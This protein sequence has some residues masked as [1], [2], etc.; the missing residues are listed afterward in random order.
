MQ[1]FDD[2]TLPPERKKELAETVPPPADDV[3]AATSASAANAPTSSGISNAPELAGYELLEELGR[4]GMGVVYKARKR[5]LDRTVAV[6][7]ILAGQ[8]ASVEEVRRFKLEAEAAARLDHPG[9]VPIYD[10]G[11]SDGNHFYSMKY[12]DGAALADKPERYLDDRRE[13]V[14]LL[15]QVAQAVHHA[16]QRGVLHRDLKPANILIDGD[17]KPLVTDL[18]LAKRLDSE[19]VTQTGIVMGT[20]GFMAP[21]QAAG[22]KDVTT[23]A[24]VFS[25]GAILHWLISGKAPFTGDSPLQIIMNTLAGD[26]PSL[27]KSRADVDVGLDLICQKC[28]RKDPLARY[29]SAAALV[30]DLQAWLTG[31]PLSVRPPTPTSLAAIWFKKNLRTVA[32]ACGCGVAC[33]LLFGAAFLMGQL[34]GFSEAEV[35]LSALEQSTGSQWPIH[36]AFLRKLPINVVYSFEFLIVIV[37]Y[38][39]AVITTLVVRPNSREGCVVSA[40]TLG[41]LAGVIAH[42]V[43]IG[44]GPIQWHSVVRG[45][46]DIQLL[47]DAIFHETDTE[48][49][50]TKK[51]LMQRYPGLDKL[52]RQQRGTILARKVMHDQSIGIPWGMW[53]GISVTL[54]L[55]TLPL[56]FSAASTGFLWLEGRRGLEFLG[57]SL[58][59]SIYIMLL[60]MFTALTL[61]GDG[62]ISAGI[63]HSL[64]LL[65]ALIF[66]LVI[67]LREATWYWRVLG[68]AL[69]LLCVANNM[70]E[71]QTIREHRKLAE[72]ARNDDEL[73]VA[74]S[75]AEKYL[76]QQDDPFRRYTTGILWLYL[77]D[78][79]RYQRHCDQLL[80]DFENAY[81][82]EVAER[83]AKLALLKPDVQ[84]DPRTIHELAEFAAGYESDALSMWF[85]FCRALSAQRQGQSQA[86]LEWTALCRERIGPTANRAVLHASSFVVDALAFVEAGDTSAAR[87]ALDKAQGIMQELDKHPE[88]VR[89]FEN[90][91]MFHILSREA[92]A[93]LREVG[94]RH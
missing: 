90:R 2:E 94:T 71:A 57:I 72:E 59:R 43:S 40:A 11:E 68:F 52:S 82:P 22:R 55:V 74:A 8:F 62:P 66:A 77:G 10:V 21:E 65:G 25:L 16:H 18:G 35:T 30:E 12:I 49:T 19:G 27:R 20:P 53:I 34:H 81:Q 32:G 63:F 79:Q 54:F 46:A 64:A 29:T 26:A 4:G 44:W 69:T 50:L 31:D 47:S 24:D 38:L 1:P 87:A 89:T 60:F 5:D 17:G 58:E 28:L 80:S 86:T 23:A 75:Y 85:F 41:L 14:K 39:G 7:M 33:G 83:L 3:T 45:S 70:S 93:K 15:I 84:K 78:V 76:R 42:C 6:K 37:I 9:I 92:E 61:P 48:R 88:W 73:L 13:A 36:F 56:S 67:S 91:L 51:A